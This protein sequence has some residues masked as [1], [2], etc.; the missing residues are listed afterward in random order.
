MLVITVMTV[1]GNYCYCDSVSRSLVMDTILIVAVL[2]TLVKVALMI[3]I[4]MTR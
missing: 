3:A 1:C 2:V 4:I